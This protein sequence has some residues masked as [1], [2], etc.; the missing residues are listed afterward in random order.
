[1]P[2]IKKIVVNYET[3]WVLPSHDPQEVAA[4]IKTIFANT[5]DYE[6][7]KANT[8]KASEELTWENDSKV[9]KEMILGIEIR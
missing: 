3:G 2:E 9:L 8:L 1:L 6:V 5:Q 7:K 4:M